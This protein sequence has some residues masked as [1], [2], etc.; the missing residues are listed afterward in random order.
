MGDIDVTMRVQVE[1]GRAARGRGEPRPPSELEDD[2]EVERVDEDD[3]PMVKDHSEDE[4]SL[5]IERG[6]RPS[7][8]RGGVVGSR[9]DVLLYMSALSESEAQDAH[10]L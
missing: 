2:D 3:E 5:E 1:V 4:T 6:E 9:R 10:Q 7:L 8:G